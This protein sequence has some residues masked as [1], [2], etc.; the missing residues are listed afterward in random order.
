MIKAIKVLR[1]IH[2]HHSHAG[3][4]LAI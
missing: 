1:N 3:C 2:R 4:T